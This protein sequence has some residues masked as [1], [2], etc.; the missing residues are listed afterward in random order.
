MWCILYVKGSH[1]W[2]VKVHACEVN[3]HD[4]RLILRFWGLFSTHPHLGPVSVFYR[5]S[6]RSN[7][8]NLKAARLGAKC[9]D[10]CWIST[11]SHNSKHKYRGFEIFARSYDKTSNPISKRFHDFVLISS[12]ALCHN[13]CSSFNSLGPTDAI[14]RWRSWSTLVQ[15]MACCLTAPSH[16]LNQCWLIVSKVM[17]HSS[18]DII[19]R[20]FGYNNQ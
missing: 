3:W 19:V 5:I 6:F 17:W 9:R 8:E 1:V 11:R 12:H 14:W 13:Q 2:T 7:L 20:R 18:E 4:V 15:V 10:A 16:Y